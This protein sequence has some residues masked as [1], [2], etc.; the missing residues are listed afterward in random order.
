[1]ILEKRKAKSKICQY[2]FEVQHCLFRQKYLQRGGQFDLLILICR[3]IPT[4]H[5]SICSHAVLTKQLWINLVSGMDT[6]TGK[7]CLVQMAVTSHSSGNVW[8]ITWHLWSLC[9]W[10]VLHLWMN[11]L[12]PDSFFFFFFSF[13]AACIYLFIF[14]LYSDFILF[15]FLLVGG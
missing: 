15:Y 9:W 13:P 10:A 3:N 11:W 7:V 14:S 4:D 1:M 6:F 5:S 8:L 2:L 12:N